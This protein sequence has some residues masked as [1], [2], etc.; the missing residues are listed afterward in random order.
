[1]VTANTNG[2][3]KLGCIVM[4]VVLGFVGYFGYKW[5]ESLWYKETIKD[6]LT[7]IVRDAATKRTVDAASVK[8]RLVKRAYENGITIHPDDI[9]ITDSTYAITI[10]VFWETP[11]DF[12][13]YTF[14]IPHS[15]D[16]TLRKMH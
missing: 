7:L 8:K 4:L 10:E 5:G 15:I 13:G 2:S 14:Y 6:E 16:R 12:P 9:I 3:S 11:V 1:M